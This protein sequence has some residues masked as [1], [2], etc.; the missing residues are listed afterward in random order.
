M[1]TELERLV[2]KALLDFEFRDRLLRDP[3]A[4]AAELGIKISDEQVMRVRKLD[5]GALARLIDCTKDASAI[6][7][8][9]WRG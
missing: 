1:E 7:T 3:A 4:A 9:C 5:R 6:V 8:P 2:G